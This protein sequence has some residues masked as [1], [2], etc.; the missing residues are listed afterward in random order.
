MTADNRI[1][2]FKMMKID[3]LKISVWALKNKQTI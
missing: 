2:L 3:S 1:C